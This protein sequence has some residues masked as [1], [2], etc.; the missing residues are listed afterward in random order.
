MGSNVSGSSNIERLHTL[1]PIMENKLKT[2][3]TSSISMKYGRNDAIHDKERNIHLRGMGSIGSVM[4]NFG[5]VP[6]IQSHNIPTL[7]GK[8][9]G[10]R[11]AAAQEMGGRYSRY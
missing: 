2:S 4:E 5:N 3:A 7:T 1:D 8:G 10:V 11:Q 9:I 6:T